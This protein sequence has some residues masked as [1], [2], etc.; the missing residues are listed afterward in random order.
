MT[1]DDGRLLLAQR[2][3]DEAAREWAAAELLASQGYF[4]QAVT[5]TYFAAFHS[6]QGLLSVHGLQASTHEGVQRLF[7][8]HFVMPGVLP[9]EAGRALSALQARGGLPSARRCRPGGLAIGPDRVHDGRRRGFR[10]SGEHLAAVEDRDRRREKVMGSPLTP[11]ERQ[12]VHPIARL[13]D[14]EPSA[15][16]VWVFGSRARGFSTEDSDLDVAVE[17]SAPEAPALR[18]WLDAVRRSAEELLADQWPGF[19]DVVGLYADDADPRLAQHVHAEGIAVWRR[20]EHV[21]G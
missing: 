18:N 19:V 21:D 3:L 9:K 10:P 14:R 16:A 15:V 8:L 2:E 4:R 7:G 5:R 17:F 6:V 1:A 20:G 13:A 12:I 11:L